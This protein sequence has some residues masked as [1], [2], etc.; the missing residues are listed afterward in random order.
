MTDKEFTNKLILGDNLEKLKLEANV[1]GKRK[2]K[3]LLRTQLYEDVEDL[4]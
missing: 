1:F 2:T 3:I 4:Q